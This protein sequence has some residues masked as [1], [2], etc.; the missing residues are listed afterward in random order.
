MGAAVPAVGVA[1]ASVIQ[2][3]VVCRSR[4]RI[5]AIRC[6]WVPTSSNVNDALPALEAARALVEAP[7]AG[8]YDMSRTDRAA[9]LYPPIAAAMYVPHALQGEGALWSLVAWD[10]LVFFVVGML[11]AAALVGRRRWPSWG[12]ALAVAAAM[13]GFLPMVRAL[14]LNQASLYVTAFVGAAW[15]AMDRGAEGVAGVFLALAAAVKPHLF[16]VVPMLWWHA[17]RAVIGAGVAGA[18]LGAASIAL[19]GVENHV[20]Y[21]TEV[22]PV[23]ARGYAFSPNQSIGGM[24]HRL[25]SDAPIDS[26]ELAAPN[27]AVM[28]ATIAIGAALYAGALAVVRRARGR[29]DLRLDVLALA[30]LVTTM[31]SPIAWGHH[32]AAALFPMAWLVGRARDGVERGWA[33]IAVVGAGLALVGS[34]FVVDGLRGAGPRLLA[35]YGLFGAMLAAGAFAAGL[36]RE[37]R[38]PAVTGGAGAA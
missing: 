11:V 22:L 8:I 19:A 26:F 16:G 12:E 25:L 32:Y 5:E 9:F 1:L 10:R 37:G 3:E 36:V 23:A 7:G 30:W 38:R 35:S 27:A 29:A 2:C 31:G 28:R 18:V 6:L 20:V 17:R 21:V 24:L 34:Y 15:V 13:V 33:R 14:A 4:E